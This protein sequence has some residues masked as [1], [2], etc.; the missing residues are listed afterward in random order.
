MSYRLDEKTDI[1]T[2]YI[3]RFQQLRSKKILNSIEERGE[4][5]EN[6]KGSDERRIGRRAR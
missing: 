1:Y 6:V 5:Y 4:N 3:E 2:T